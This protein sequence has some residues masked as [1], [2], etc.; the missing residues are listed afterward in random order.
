MPLLE[1]SVGQT[2]PPSDGSYKG[3]SISR[4]LKWKFGKHKE[5]NRSR[6]GLKTYE[7]MLPLYL[8]SNSDGRDKENS[9]PN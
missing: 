9:F 3:I 5:R 1:S 8:R 4:S 6:H 2:H 7:E